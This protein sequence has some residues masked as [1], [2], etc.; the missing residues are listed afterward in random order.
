MSRI[1]TF[2]V[3]VAVLLQCCC[4]AVAVLLQCCCSAVAAALSRGNYIYTLCKSPTHT[5]GRVMSQILTCDVG[6]AALLQQSFRVGNA[7]TNCANHPH[8]HW[9]VTSRIYVMWEL[10]R[11]C[12]SPFKRRCAYTLCRSR[13]HIWIC[14]VR[15]IN[16][17]CGSCSAVA[18]EQGCVR[19]CMTYPYVR[20]IKMKC[21][22]C[23]AVAAVLLRERCP[24]IL[25]GGYD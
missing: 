10:Q 7:F 9:R 19:Q 23:S 17:S 18:D 4:S 14:L 3:G 12:S 2:H 16:T 21:G 1:F 6:V 15:H 13:T 8:T 5:Y 11:C 20:H 24:Y 22:S 25:W